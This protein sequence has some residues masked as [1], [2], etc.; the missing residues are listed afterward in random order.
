M[1]LVGCALLLCDQ[2]Q[3]AAHEAGEPAAAP[4]ARAELP[5]V[6][7]PDLPDPLALTDPVEGLPPGERHDGAAA[8]VIDEPAPAASVTGRVLDQDDATVAAVTVSLY[9]GATR[10]Q[11][12]TDAAGSFH[13]AD[14]APGNYRLFVEGRTLPE[15]LLPP[16]R[17]HV[18][19]EP[20]PSPSGIHGTSFR[21]TAGTERAVDLR[22]FAAGTVRGRIVSARGDP[23][24]GALISV[25]S[26]AGVTDQARTDDSGRFELAALYPGAYVASARLE[27]SFPDAAVSAPLPLRFELAPRQ[28]LVLDDLVPAV[29]GHVLR[30]TV[31]DLAGR[32]VPGLPVLCREERE[33]G[34]GGEWRC[35]TDAEGR[36]DVGRV[37]SAPLLVAVEARSPGRSGGLERLREPV[38]PLRVDARY[39]DAVIEVAPIRVE[40]ARPF[41]VVGRV[42]VDPAWAHANGLERWRASVAVRGLDETAAEDGEAA[43]DLPVNASG[44]F[45]WSCATPHD[46]VELTVIVRG[47]GGAEVERSERLQPVA[48]QTR[49]LEI[50]IP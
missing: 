31:V 48:D 49:E 24:A 41:Q 20:E 39:A 21:L 16:W 10:L 34:L 28:V 47:A 35:V 32:P 9:R 4:R 14:L 25:R 8:A 45:A 36:Y 18:A 6:S 29:A 37:P 27:A 26:T 2:G 19:R 5:D 44:S 22:V 42:R 13:F 15:D 1:A 40:A 7:A 50:A 12:A 43:S 46:E 33:D 11:T 3:P 17:Q 23:V 30:G 38:E